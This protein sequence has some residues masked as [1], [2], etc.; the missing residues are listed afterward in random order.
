M[1]SS[2]RLRKCTR[3]GEH[4]LCM[5]VLDGWLCAECREHPD[6]VTLVRL[7][8]ALKMEYAKIQHHQKRNEE[9]KE[10]YDIPLRTRG[11]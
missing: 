4:R 10:K 3:C 6:V 1:A 7:V 11:H 8:A 5:S 2:F 9:W